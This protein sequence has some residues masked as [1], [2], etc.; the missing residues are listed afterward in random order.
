MEELKLLSDVELG[1][2]IE[3]AT[4]FIHAV[5]RHSFANETDQE[6]LMV[7]NRLSILAVEYLYFEDL[8]ETKESIF[9]G[10][11]SETI[12]SYS[13]SMTKPSAEA[14]TTGQTGI[15]EMDVLFQSLKETYGG[16]FLFGITRPSRWE[17]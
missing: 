12:G 3:R 13:Y 6:K 10:V 14:I 15:S 4:I 17:R 11:S 5:A 7:L 9:N 2:L 16:S 8:P 1:Y